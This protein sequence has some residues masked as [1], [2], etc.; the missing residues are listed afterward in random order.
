MSKTAVARLSIRTAALKENMRLLQSCG[1]AQSQLT[2]VL[3]ADCYG[4]GLKALAPHFWQQ[5]ARLYYVAQFDEGLLLKSILPQARIAVLSGLVG[6]SVQDFWQ[7]GLEPVLNSL[8]QVQRYLAAIKAARKP[9]YQLFIHADT[10]MNRLGLDRQEQELLLQENLEAFDV[11]LL[12]HYACADEPEQ[13][14]NARQ[15]QRFATLAELLKSK[16][17]TLTRSM[18][19]SAALLSRRP[20]ASFEH[21]RPGLSLYGA[22]PFAY[23]EQINGRL[24]LEPLACLEAMILQLRFVVKGESIGYGASFVAPKDMRIA[25][26]ALG[27]AD[28]WLRAGLGREVQVKGQKAAI[29]GR[30]SMDSM[31]ID[32]TNIANLTEGDWAQLFWARGD[33]ERLSAQSG[34]IANEWMTNLGARY[35]RLYLD[36]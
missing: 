6:A 26:L 15:E 2:P 33:I 12:S 25:L 14:L 8:S 29:I 21:L 11:V 3:K 18:A 7:A 1:S 31:A 4:M 35:Q 34:T 5:G 28:G 27:Y 36:E 23:G 10:G 30:V 16:V 19:N 22:L 17:G 13:P 24:Q 32:V 9:N 20:S